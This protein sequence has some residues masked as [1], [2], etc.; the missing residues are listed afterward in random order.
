[1]S[2]ELA[3]VMRFL[4]DSGYVVRTR[5]DYFVFTNKF[6]TEFVGKD[7]GLVPS[8]R[9]I[10]MKSE[11]TSILIPPAKLTIATVNE[12]YLSFI[13]ACNIPRRIVNPKGESY[14]ANQFSKDGAKAFGKLLLRVNSG[15]IDM[16]LLVHTVQLYY[17]SSVGY[18]LKIGN[19]IGD[20][21]W[22]MDYQEL[23]ARLGK[24]T[25]NEHIKQE[26]ADDNTGSSR[27][28]FDSRSGAGKKVLGPGKEG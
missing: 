12:A 11:T 24:G 6:Y 26:V 25:I 9:P 2:E 17:K 28:R 1:M 3:E 22:E 20:G 15:E 19:Y 27:Y 21:A 8:V 4:G 23:V 5:Q 14:A 10:I 13:V 16:E 18:K 7:V